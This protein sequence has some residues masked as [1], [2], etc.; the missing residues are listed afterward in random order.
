MNAVTTFK[1]SGLELQV[2][3]LWTGCW[4]E[5]ALGVLSSEG[6]DK[7]SIEQCCAQELEQDWA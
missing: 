2:V 4:S 7:P 6:T 1:G 5:W 3:A